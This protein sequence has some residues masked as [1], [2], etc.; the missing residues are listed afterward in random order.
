VASNCGTFTATDGS[1]YNL[2]PLT[3]SSSD[4]SG[5]DTH[6]FTYWFNFCQDVNPKNIPGC[7]TATPIAQ[8]NPTGLACISI[9]Y[10]PADI[11]D[12][13]RD[14]ADGVQITYVNSLDKCA[15]GAV[16]RTSNLVLTCNP[17]VD[18]A[19]DSISEPAICTYMFYIHSRYAC[20]IKDGKNGRK[21]N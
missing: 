7:K 13:P 11:T 18:Y 17:A 2:V 15:G 14:P 10:L 12:H 21:T 5:K 9:G 8:L 16:P 4:Y 3:N 1:K 6:G 19:L 20:P